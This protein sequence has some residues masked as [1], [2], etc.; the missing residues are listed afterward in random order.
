MRRCGVGS[1][2][3]LDNAGGGDVMSGKSGVKRGLVMDGAPHRKVR[4]GCG[5]V[6]C[7]VCIEGA[8]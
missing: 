4:C 1:K 8:S 2:S 6:V 3:T 7:W 5:R